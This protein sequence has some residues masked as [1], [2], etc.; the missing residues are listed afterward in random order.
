MGKQFI[1]FMGSVAP[2]ELGPGT[3]LWRVYSGQ[4]TNNGWAELLPFRE[5]TT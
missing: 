5:Q 4:S 2:G 3:F 1:S